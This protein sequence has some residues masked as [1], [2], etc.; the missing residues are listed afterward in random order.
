MYDLVVDLM[1]VAAYH[2]PIRTVHYTRV[3]H[4]KIAI[5]R[6]AKNL[7]APEGWLGCGDPFLGFG[8]EIRASAVLSKQA[9]HVCHADH[10]YR[11]PRLKILTCIY[12]GPETGMS[13]S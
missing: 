13:V 6:I 11:K 2:M 9:G 3:W 1:R 8:Q 4:H 10:P 5:V 7:Q 12:F